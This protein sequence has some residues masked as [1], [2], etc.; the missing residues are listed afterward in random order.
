MVNLCSYI[1]DKTIY[2]TIN[3]ET[4]LKIRREEIL[5]LN[6]YIIWTENGRLEN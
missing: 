6:L 1:L 2:L 3:R 4:G 5:V